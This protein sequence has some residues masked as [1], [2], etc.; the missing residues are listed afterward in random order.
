MGLEESSQREWKRRLVQ[1]ALQRIAGIAG[2]EVDQPITVGGDLGYRNK[3]ELVLGRDADARPVIGFHEAGGLSGVVDVTD[4]AVQH[5]SANRVLLATRRIL[6]EEP[7][8]WPASTYRREDPFRLVI[9]RS[10]S[11]GALLVAVRET[12]A[13][14][15][16]ISEFTRRLTVACPE[17]RSVARLRARPGR[18]GGTRVEAIHGPDWIEERVGE[19]TFRLPASSF[20]QV[21]TEVGSAL[22]HLVTSVAAP[23]EGVPVLDLY[24]GVGSIGLHLARR[25]A[26]VTVCEADRTAV[27]C[28][29]QAIRAHR[30]TGVRFYHGDV[31]GFLEAEEPPAGAGE[32][33]VANPPRDGL[34]R[35]V[36]QA[37]LARRPARVILV[38]CDPP[39]MARDLRALTGGDMRLNRVSPLDMFPQTSHV[40]TVAVLD[41]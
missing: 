15:P 13:E 31:R 32:I 14:F 34:G 10:W 41:R 9:R 12:R 23:G 24:G 40:E 36:S 35:G 19:L 1:D 17:L 8:L 20:L 25:G 6:L 38:S 37:I 39:T 27:V 11:T 28:G 33:I 29:R 7:N 3:V 16:A 22:V 30:L 5:D 2:V 18:R 21:N 4:C 26:R